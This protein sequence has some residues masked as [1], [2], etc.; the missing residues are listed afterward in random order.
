[1]PYTCA[2][3]TYYENEQLKEEYFEINN[4]K[5]GEYKRYYENG[6]LC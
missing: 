6:K 3:K 2:I 1:M 5:E 4:K